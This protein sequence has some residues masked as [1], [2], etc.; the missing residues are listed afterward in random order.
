M[1]GFGLDGKDRMVVGGCL[2][3]VCLALVLVAWGMGFALSFVS[4][5]VR[6]GFLS[7]FT[8][9][10]FLSVFM[11]LLLYV[12]VG[13]ENLEGEKTFLASAFFSMVT[14]FTGAFSWIF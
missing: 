1:Y 6:I 13:Q 3:A 11:A 5:P 2:A 10:L 8:L 12:A 14:F 9:A 4:G 7:A